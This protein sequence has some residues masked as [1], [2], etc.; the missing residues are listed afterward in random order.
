MHIT[1]E[2]NSAV[3]MCF[4]VNFEINLELVKGEKNYGTITRRN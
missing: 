1:I 2:L 4:N 3:A